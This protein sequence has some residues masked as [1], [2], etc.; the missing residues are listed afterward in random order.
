MFQRPRREIWVDKVKT[1]EVVVNPGTHRYHRPG[2]Q[3]LWRTSEGRA[4]LQYQGSHNQA[5]IFK[6]GTGTAHVRGV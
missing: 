1:A 2:R 6:T 4:V 3:F 5:V